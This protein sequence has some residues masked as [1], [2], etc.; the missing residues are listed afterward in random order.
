MKVI[1][2]QDDQGSRR[3]WKVLKGRLTRGENEL[4]TSCYQL[5]MA[6]DGGKQRLTDVANAPTLLRLAGRVGSE[7]V[8]KCNQL[9]VPAAE[10]ESDPTNVAGER[11]GKEGSQVVTDCHRFRL[12]AA[13]GK[14][15]GGEHA[16]AER[17]QC[18][19]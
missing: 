18:L 1:Q 6:A 10:G 8:T 19:P 3:Y 14:R 15:H 11:L 9:R 7:S 13:N 12:P 17:Y 2:H 4:V 5:T 16:G